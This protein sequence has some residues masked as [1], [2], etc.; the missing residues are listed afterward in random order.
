[1]MQL[2]VAA[3]LALAQNDDKAQAN[4]YDDAWKSAW[5]TH[6][7]TVLS[8]GSGK[9]AGFVLHI[10][11]SITYSS[12]YGAWIKGGSGTQLELIANR[13]PVS[14]SSSLYR[15]PEIGNKSRLW[16]APSLSAG[17]GRV[18]ASSRARTR[19]TGTTT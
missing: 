2:A 16:I 7:Q 12:A 10:G 5:K 3:L 14:P 1:M 9:T 8:G 6:C 18:G 4:G 15:H 17:T 11:D 13:V 19:Q